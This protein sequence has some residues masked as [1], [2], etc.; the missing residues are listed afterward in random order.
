MTLWLFFVLGTTFG[1][2]NHTQKEMMLVQLHKHKLLREDLS[3]L[4]AV[5]P[6]ELCA[7]SNNSAAPVPKTARATL[8]ANLMDAQKRLSQHPKPVKLMAVLKNTE[9]HLQAA[10]EAMAQFYEGLSVPPDAYAVAHLADAIAVR[11]AVPGKPI[12]VLYPVEAELGRLLWAEKIDVAISNEA[13]VEAVATA[14]INLP[15]THRLGVHLFVDTGN[16]R[17][18][19]APQDAG[20]ILAAVLRH[21]EVLE[22]RGV[23]SHFCCDIRRDRN[24]HGRRNGNGR[25][26]DDPV[27]TAQKQRIASLFA[28]VEAQLAEHYKSM[29]SMPRHVVQRH[30]ATS[31]AVMNEE[32]EVFYDMVRV[33]T[34]LAHGLSSGA[35][36]GRPVDRCLV[37]KLAGCLPGARVQA[38]KTLP[39]KKGLEWC[40]SYSCLQ[41]PRGAKIP[42]MINRPLRVASLS[43]VCHKVANPYES[44]WTPSGGAFAEAEAV[45]DGHGSVVMLPERSSLNAT[46][47]LVPVAHPFPEIAVDIIYENASHGLPSSASVTLPKE[48]SKADWDVRERLFSE[49]QCTRWGAPRQCGTYFL[50]ELWSSNGDVYHGGAFIWGGKGPRPTGS[51]LMDSVIS[52]SDLGAAIAGVAFVPESYASTGVLVLGLG[53]AFKIPYLHLR[54]SWYVEVVELDPL[55]L[56]LA[57]Q[58]FDF[59][60]LPT[61]VALNGEFSTQCTSDGR[62]CVA[63]KDALAHMEA[64]LAAGRRFATVFIDIGGSDGTSPVYNYNDAEQ[65]RFFTVLQQLA[66]TA[67]F[68]SISGRDQARAFATL[69]NTYNSVKCAPVKMDPSDP[70]KSCYALGLALDT[71]GDKA[72]RKRAAAIDAAASWAPFSLQAYVEKLHPP[73]ASETTKVTNEVANSY[74]TLEVKKFTLLQTFM[75]GMVLPAAACL[76]VMLCRNSL[77]AYVSKTSGQ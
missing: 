71:L 1:A 67:S 24:E 27:H 13:W 77:K 28:A 11:R 59:P 12:L 47:S 53:T 55:V 46:M 8:T 51:H 66:P 64:L 32:F 58:F 42:F 5:G 3:A 60:D 9:Y 25:D 18:G 38:V 52:R 29:P 19:A 48:F 36:L 34:L 49:L 74:H 56:R 31:N 30:V 14:L 76:L 40:L 2:F 54:T 57:Q 26:E 50:R 63:L 70:D 10:P 65:K 23:M 6:A 61:M 21:S 17:A 44:V 33:G 41:G 20:N 7:P 69:H 37:G 22:L 72:A 35:W 62:L 43:G 45:G 75:L 68:N 39:G 16:A 4:E 73:D 15:R